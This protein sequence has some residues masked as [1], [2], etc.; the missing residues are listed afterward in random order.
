M[1]TKNACAP[2]QEAENWIAAAGFEAGSECLAGGSRCA[3]PGSLL[4]DASSDLQV[5]GAFQDLV[6]LLMLKWHRCLFRM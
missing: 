4:K 5:A 3:C 6:V 1:R 2:K